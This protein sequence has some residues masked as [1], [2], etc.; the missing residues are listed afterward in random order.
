MH[1]QHF[2]EAG[3]ALPL[4]LAQE[5]RGGVIVDGNESAHGSHRSYLSLR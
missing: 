4:A 5:R 3:D 1:R 2:G